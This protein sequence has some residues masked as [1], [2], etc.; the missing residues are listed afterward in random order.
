MS[1]GQ[2]QQ[3]ATWDR[4]RSLGWGGPTRPPHAAPP[5]PAGGSW[6]THRSDPHGSLEVEGPHSTPHAPPASC[7]RGRPLRPDFQSKRS[8]TAPRHLPSLGMC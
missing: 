5:P 3:A 6:P 1:L 4:T 8:L 7:R 2:S